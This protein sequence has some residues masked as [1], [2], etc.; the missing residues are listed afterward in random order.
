MLRRHADDHGVMAVD[1]L[2]ARGL[3]AA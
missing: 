1:P 3:A 2:P